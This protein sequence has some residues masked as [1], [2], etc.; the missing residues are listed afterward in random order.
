MQRK[1]IKPAVN[2]SL[3]KTATKT[4]SFLV[5]EISKGSGVTQKKIRPELTVVKSSFRKLR[6]VVIVNS[7]GMSLYKYTNGANPKRK[8]VAAAIAPTPVTGKHFV[9]T[10]GRGRHTGFFKRQPGKR[11]QKNKRSASGHYYKSS[12]ISEL[13]INPVAKGYYK[14]QLRDRADRFMAQEFNQ[15]LPRELNWRLSRQKLK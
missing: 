12:K 15:I 10:V 9:A 11:I 2:S 1:V 4:R 7:K 8:E 6:S 13:Y 3:N 5:K 14:G